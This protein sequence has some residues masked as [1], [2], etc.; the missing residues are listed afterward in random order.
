MRYFTCTRN[1]GIRRPNTVGRLHR[2]FNDY[3]T[4]G[5]SDIKD[6]VLLKG[7]PYGGV[8]FLVFFFFFRKKLP[9]VVH[10]VRDVCPSFCHLWK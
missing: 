8:S 2:H 7:R 10:V 3:N 6:E 1:M 9:V 4:C 5:I